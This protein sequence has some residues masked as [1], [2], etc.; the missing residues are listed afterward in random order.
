[1]GSNSKVIGATVGGAVGM[2]F[3]WLLT[4]FG[5]IEVPNE[6]AGAITTLCSAGVTY[7]FPSNG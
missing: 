5:G 7:F 6:I 2:I 1:M 3:T 4:Q